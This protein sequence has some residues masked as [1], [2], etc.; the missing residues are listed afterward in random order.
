MWPRSDLEGEGGS[1]QG[2]CNQGPGRSQKSSISGSKRSGS[3]SK[4]IRKGEGPHLFGPMWTTKIS[5]LLRPGLWLQIY[6]TPVG[7]HDDSSRH[8]GASPVLQGSQPATRRE[9]SERRSLDGFVCRRAPYVGTGIAL[10][11]GRGWEARVPR[12]LPRGGEGTARPG[13]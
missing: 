13:G 7:R 5:D 8:V 4:H 3:A 2:I 9:D 1:N 10:L 11:S 6:R 12:P